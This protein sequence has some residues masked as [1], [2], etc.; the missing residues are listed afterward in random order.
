MFHTLF[1][2]LEWLVLD[3]ADRLL[4]LSF[5]DT[6]DIVDGVMPRSRRTILCSATIPE[7]LLGKA[8]SWCHRGYAFVDCIGDASSSHGQADTMEVVATPESMNDKQFYVTCPAHRIV[9]ALH[10]ILQDEITEGS[11]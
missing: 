8:Q 2:K 3:E 10:N 6:L 9:T 4:E 7:V 5:A 1:E 11:L